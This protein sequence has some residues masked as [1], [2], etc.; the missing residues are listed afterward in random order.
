MKIGNME[1]YGVIYKITNKVNGKVYIG[2][3]TLG[4][5]TR[6]CYKGVGIERVYQKHR[7]LKDNGFGYNAHLLSA[8]E[9]YGLENFVLHEIYDVAFSR[10][11][12]DIKEISYIVAH[13]SYKN[14]YNRNSGGKGNSGFQNPK[15]GN[16]P[17]SISVVQISLDGDFVKK[18]ESISEASA[19]IS[20]ASDISWCCNKGFNG[21]KSAGGFLWVR[22]CDY[23][24]Q[25][26][27]KYNDNRGEYNKEPVVC[28]DIDGNFVKEYSSISE[29][30]EATQR[31]NSG[32]ISSCCK[33]LRK[34]S[35]GYMWLYK[36]DY[37]PSENYQYTALHTGEKK[38]VVQ[39]SL[40]GTFIKAYDSISDA[41]SITKTDGSKIVTCCK[42]NRKSANG[43]MWLYATEYD[44][45]GSY[46]YKKDTTA[47]SVYMCGL[48][49]EI[50]QVFDSLTNAEKLTNISLKAISRCLNG[51]SKTSGGYIWKYKE[52]A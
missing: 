10:K 11:E 2:Q 50:L 51:K 30:V 22:E 7:S 5:N 28:L 41:E 37:T 4:I 29:A 52:T 27:Y 39:L 17:C 8:I 32:K 48:D 14:G 19:E 49:G 15:G 26:I 9:K 20:T 31:T 3:T 24:P 13:D 16:S 35:G 23:N 21:E 47:K 38:P 18:W 33:G 40:D 44:V 34:S 6:Y 46:Y 45:N 43:F 36:E 25:E 1:V 42:G 12:L